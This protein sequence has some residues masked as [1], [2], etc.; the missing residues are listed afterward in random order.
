MQTTADGA[1]RDGNGHLHGCIF[2]VP[3]VGAG[4]ALVNTGFGRGRSAA[5]S[6]LSAM[7]VFAVAVLV[8]L[9]FGFGFQGFAGEAGP[10][11]EV[12]G[13]AMESA[14]SRAADDARRGVQWFGAVAGGLPATVQCG[15][16]GHDSARRGLRAAGGWAQ[17][18]HRRHCWPELPTRFLRTG[19]GAEAGWHNWAGWQVRKRCAGRRRRR[20][21][22]GC[23]ADLRRCRSPGFWERGTANTR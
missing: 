15:D 8:Y 13:T 23:S 17:V 5:H 12:G 20:R 19:Y 1:E 9:L 14:G 18:A 22:P 21:D 16:C 6:M 11:G 4:L 2:L 10:P 7:C 3:L